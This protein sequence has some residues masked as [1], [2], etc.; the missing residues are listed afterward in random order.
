MCV[1]EG[2]GCKNLDGATWI[3]LR[4]LAP[5]LTSVR[6]YN[7]SVLAAHGPQEQGLSKLLLPGGMW[8]LRKIGADGLS[9]ALQPATRLS[10]LHIWYVSERDGTSE[11]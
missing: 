2:R 11:R 9:L 5:R 8:E 7:G 6:V 3:V 10:S 4:A 1:W